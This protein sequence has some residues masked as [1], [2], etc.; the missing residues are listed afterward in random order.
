MAGEGVSFEALTRQEEI[1]ARAFESST[2]SLAEGLYHPEVIYISPTVRLFGWPT[3]IHGL[4]RTIEFINLTVQRVR[5]VRYCAV[6]SAI[7]AG[8]SSAFVR[9]HFDWDAGGRRLRSNYVVIYRYREGRIGRQ[10]LFYDPS[11]EL[12]VLAGG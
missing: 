4:R 10:E 11:G 8:G 6:E 5:N 2:L 1:F 9:I 12:E 3:R 7:V